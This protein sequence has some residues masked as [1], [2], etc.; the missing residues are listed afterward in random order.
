MS[1]LLISV[2]L[3]GILSGCA[4]HSAVPLH[5]GG[6]LYD[7][8]RTWNNPHAFGASVTNSQMERCT[9]QEVTGA[10]G[11][12]TIKLNNDN[13]VTISVAPPVYTPGYLQ[14]LFTSVIQ[15]GTWLGSAALISS[16]SSDSNTTVNQSQTQS[17]NVMPPKGHR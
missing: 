5:R 3:V 4:G 1:R 14:G 15:V 2:M 8:Q 16:G 13:C 12:T 17:V 11:V 9:G 7:V 10:N 6:D